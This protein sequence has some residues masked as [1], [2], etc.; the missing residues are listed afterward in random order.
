M[1]KLAEA[2]II[3]IN[4]DDAYKAL[5]NLKNAGYESSCIVGPVKT[6]S[7]YKINLI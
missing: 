6:K 3:S 2:L 7:E 4:E 5:S 1:P